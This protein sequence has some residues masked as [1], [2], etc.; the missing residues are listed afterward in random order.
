MLYAGFP[1]ISIILRE[2]RLRFSD[3]CWRSKNEV[4]S[5]LVLWKLKHGKRSVRGQTRIFVNLLEVDIGGPRDCMLAAMN[6]RAS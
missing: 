2:R 4:V 5:D 6:D 3:H 1:R